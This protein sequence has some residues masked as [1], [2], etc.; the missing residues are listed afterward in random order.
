MVVEGRT[1]WYTAEGYPQ[2]F[3]CDIYN[4]WEAGV[5]IGTEVELDGV[6][7]HKIY[8]SHYRDEILRTDGA[9][10]NDDESLV[11]YIREEGKK[12]YLLIVDPD[13]Q[14]EWSAKWDRYSDLF[15]QYLNVYPYYMVEYEGGEVLIYDF[16]KCDY[17]VGETREVY[18]KDNY[19]C[20]FLSEDVIQ[21]SG[22][23]YTLL[24][25]KIPDGIQNRSEFKIVEGIGIIESPWSDLLFFYPFGYDPYAVIQR[26]I[27]LRYVT[28]K[29]NNIIFEQD[30]G[31]RLWDEMSG[32]YNVSATPNNS[33]TEWYNLQG[34]KAN[35]PLVPGIYIQR[36]GQSTCKVIVK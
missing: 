31:T 9:E 4:S 8:V 20:T 2:R 22:R 35:T 11:G 19:K 17:V 25:C 18:T 36:N 5:S 3:H 28:D 23:E 33:T 29:D 7:W 34:V 10:F 1:W 12:V 13:D 21:N 24:N 27:A 26:H 30:G 16:N 15:G 6:K 14:D 32:V